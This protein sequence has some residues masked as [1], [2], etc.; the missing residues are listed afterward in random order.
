[1]APARIVPSAGAN[2]FLGHLA[3]ARN[4]ARCPLVEEPETLTP[5]ADPP[6]EPSTDLAPPPAQVSPSQVSGRDVDPAPAEGGE[7]T[8]DDGGTPDAASQLTALAEHV[9]EQ[10]D[11]AHKSG[12]KEAQSRMQPEMQRQAQLL[13]GID[14]AT[15]ETSSAL[16]DLRD[17]AQEEGGGPVS[18]KEF[19]KLLTKHAATINTLGGI[20]QQR[21][22]VAGW[23]GM[24]N[25]LGIE[26]G[27]ENMNEQFSERLTGLMKQVPDPTVIP[28]IVDAITDAKVKAA[29]EK[30]R[31]KWEKQVREN[32]AAESRNEQR[33]GQ[34]APAKPTGGGGGK[35]PDLNTVKGI[36]AAA[37]G[38]QLS[39]TESAQRIQDLAAGGLQGG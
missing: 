37:R 7:P 17:A 32:M 5:T 2:P 15:S 8:G 35:P 25:D 34:P 36:N 16:I 27:V 18:L 23:V 29:L 39:P 10:K 13:A 22:G 21:F 19:D 30:E 12:R 33:N 3:G 26:A 6:S 11:A 1:M 9:Q 24:V 31:P 4:K 20:D 28:D 38:G 14:Q